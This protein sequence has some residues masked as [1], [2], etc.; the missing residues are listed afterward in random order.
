MVNQQTAKDELKAWEELA[1]F[2][3]GDKKPAGVVDVWDI[4][5]GGDFDLN[6]VLKDG[7]T[8]IK[9][10]QSCTIVVLD[11]FFDNFR[12][13]TANRGQDDSALQYVNPDQ[14]AEAAVSN[15]TH[16]CAAFGFGVGQ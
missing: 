2:I 4:S 16:Y 13:R 1:G 3:F 14:L 5:Q 7:S 8:L 12:T 10:W 11:N 15:G 6:S 9:D